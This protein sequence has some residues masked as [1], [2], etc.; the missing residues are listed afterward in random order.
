MGGE[1]IHNHWRGSGADHFL[2]QPASCQWQDPSEVPLIYKRTGVELLVGT[3]P[4]LCSTLSETLFWARSIRRCAT[5]PVSDRGV[6]LASD[7]LTVG[8]S[9]GGA[10][11]ARH[12]SFIAAQVD[13]QVHLSVGLGEWPTGRA[14]CEPS[15]EPSR[16]LPSHRRD[17][18][19]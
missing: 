18:N 8:A 5:S 2:L 9:C 1:A 15:G 12:G 4:V 14:A 3:W 16:R 13:L 11:G 10:T 17:T 19:R 6:Q 7:S